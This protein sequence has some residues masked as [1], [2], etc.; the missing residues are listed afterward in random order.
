MSIIQ[1]DYPMSVKMGEFCTVQKGVEIGEDTRICN[2]VNLYGCK[3]GERCMIG[4]FVEIQRGAVIGNDTKISSHSFVCSKVTIGDNCFIAHGVNFTNDWFD[5][6]DV[7]F[8]EKD[9]KRT[10]VEDNVLIGSGATI[11]PVK[12]GHHAVIGAGAV[13][14]KDVLPYTIVVGN[15]AKQIK[16]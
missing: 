2:Y 1:S 16:K 14:T 4:T 13:V 15:P 9:W 3:I 5:N 6:G 8:D 10:I 7:H 11:L 12:I